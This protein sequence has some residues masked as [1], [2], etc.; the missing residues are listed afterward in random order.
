MHQFWQWKMVQRMAMED[1]TLKCTSFGNEKGTLKCT[2]F[3]Y[4]KWY[5]VWQWKMEL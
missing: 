1:G 4:V 2:S 5:K 3:G